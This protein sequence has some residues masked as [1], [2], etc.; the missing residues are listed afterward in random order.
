MT[1]ENLIPRHIRSKRRT[2]ISA[3]DVTF[4]SDLLVRDFSAPAPGAKL[5]G[6][7]TYMR[8]TSGWLYLATVIDC[9]CK[10]VVGW[11]IQPHMKASLVV[12]ALEMASRRVRITPG[13]TVFHSDRGSQYLS[14]KFQ[15][16]LTQLNIRQSVGRTGTALDNALAES[17]FGFLKSE[18]L[19]RYPIADQHR[20]RAQVVAYIEDFYNT[21]R[22]H[23]SLNYRSPNQ[24][25]EEYLK[26]KE[27]A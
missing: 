7:I 8:T 21:E 26:T 27:V 23:S 11:A 3:T 4:P 2:T 25:H 20:T 6:D 5:V 10:E 16:A 1:R 15:R 24:V 9:C 18:C 22:L 14:G 13:E 17:F 19:Y 12:E